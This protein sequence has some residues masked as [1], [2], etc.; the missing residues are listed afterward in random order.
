MEK[1]QL[2]LVSSTPHIRRHISVELQYLFIILALLPCVVC[3]IIFYKFNALLILSVSI[4]SCYVFD[5]FFSFMLLGHFSFKDFSSVITGIILG[6]IMPAQIPIYYVI[7]AGIVS[8]V[9]AKV[10]FGGQGKELV[11]APSLGACVLASL[12]SGFTTT[13]CAYSILTHD[14]A[15]PLITFAEGE[16]GKIAILD[17]LLGN[18]GG[19]IGTTSAICCVVGGVFLCATRVYDY[20]IPV[21]AVVAFAIVIA[22][23]KGMGAVLPEMLTGSFLFACAFMLPSHSSSPALWPAKVVYAIGFGVMAAFVRTEYLFG[24]TGVFFCLLMMNVLA[25]L[26]DLLASVFFRGRRVKKYE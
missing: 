23:T 18:G 19:L 13:M 2:Y 10:M 4:L 3:S 8:V 7:I 5:M 11:S 14:V 17:L 21:L 15:S 25:P 6:L 26:L 1:Q 16:Y 24:E 20:Y 9:I 22:L 12:V